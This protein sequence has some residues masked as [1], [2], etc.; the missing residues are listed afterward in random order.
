MNDTLSKIKVMQ[1]FVDGKKIEVTNLNIKYWTPIDDPG[2][3]WTEC[4]YRIRES[5][6]DWE[7]VINNAL[8][9]EFSNYEDFSKPYIG[10]LQA[11]N[12]DNFKMLNG[13][14]YEFCRIRQDHI[15]FWGGNNSCPLPKGL[16]MSGYGHDL[17][18]ICNTSDY[19][20]LDWAN[21]IA[22]KVHGLAYGWK[23]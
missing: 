19:R 21:I 8:D 13:M 17:S 22:F 14:E 20:D 10:K 15:H 1:A 18:H 16:I 23:Y 5:K 2:W 3:D 9:C 4:D 11:V 7:P 12:S 6:I